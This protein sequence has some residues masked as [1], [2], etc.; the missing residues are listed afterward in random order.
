[1]SVLTDSPYP[2]AF[3]IRVSEDI[4]KCWLFSGILRP[5]LSC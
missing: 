1:M 2:A 4:D 5:Q 3:E